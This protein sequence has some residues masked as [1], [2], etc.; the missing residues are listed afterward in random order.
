MRD[1]IDVHID[2]WNDIGRDI[3]R[4]VSSCAPAAGGR[5]A[6]PPE[7]LMHRLGRDRPAYRASTTSRSAAIA[8][9][10]SSR[11]RHAQ[12]A[13]NGARSSPSRVS[14]RMTHGT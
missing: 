2:D 4:A 7:R 14:A 9:R 12:S 5:A 11:S 3:C 8:G 13:S 1:G 6:G 10:S